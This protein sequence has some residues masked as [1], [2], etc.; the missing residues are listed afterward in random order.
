M[1]EP[2]FRRL[3]KLQTRRREAL[4]G[5]ELKI[6][7]KTSHVL[8]LEDKSSTWYTVYCMHIHRASD[9]RHVNDDQWVLRKR[10]S[11]L[12]AFRRLFCKRIEDWENTVRRE[13]TRKPAARSQQIY[14][15]VS[16]AMRRALSPSFPKKHFRSDNPAVVRG[17]ALRLPDFVRK[18]VGV[19]TDLAVFKRNSQLQAGGFASSWAQLCTIFSE[20]E[21]FLEIPQPQKDAEIQLQSA[22]LALKDFTDGEN[23]KGEEACEQ[24][25]PIC[26][27]GYPATEKVRPV[28]SL[29]CGH[30]FHEDCVIDW[31]STSPTCPL[32][33]Q[34]S[35]S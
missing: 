12:E 1:D 27:N 13:F 35:H 15:V 21:T 5:S 30:H 17:R 26:L 20:L 6:R 28:V 29:P 11:E 4:I 23:A 14:A 16:N 7:T 22:V 31:F 10:Y 9:S 33:R 18:L 24:V 19:Y 2:H 34:N 8:A 32:C 25:C 3:L